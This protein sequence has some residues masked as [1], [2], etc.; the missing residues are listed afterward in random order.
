MPACRS[1]TV[2]VFAL[3]IFYLL[4]LIIGAA[5][6]AAIEGPE[7][8]KLKQGLRKVRNDFKA[9]HKS[10]VGGKYRVRYPNT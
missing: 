10:C 1:S 5:I 3:T 6:F 8:T 9:A 7:E 2:R 4:Y